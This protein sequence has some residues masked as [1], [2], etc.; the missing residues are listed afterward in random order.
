[1]SEI[2][3]YYFI[4]ALSATITSILVHFIPIFKLA[5]AGTVNSIVYT[6]TSLSLIVWSVM[7]FIASPI[8]I[9]TLLFDNVK[10]DFITQTYQATIAD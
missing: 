7:Y 1:M 3:F 10:N 9:R 5:K 4:F 6:H 8:M 2:L